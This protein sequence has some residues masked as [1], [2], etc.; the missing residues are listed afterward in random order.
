MTQNSENIAIFQEIWLR[1][2][3]NLREE[4]MGLL[5][6]SELGSLDHSEPFAA[7]KILWGGFSPEERNL[8]LN[9]VDRNDP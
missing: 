9:W 5:M 6:Q 7:V 4:M 2:A 1:T 8:I 3:P